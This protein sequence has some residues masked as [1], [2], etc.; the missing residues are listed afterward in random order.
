MA[1]DEVL[2]GIDPTLV[3]LALDAPPTTAVAMAEALAA[4]LQR[5]GHDPAALTVDFGLGAAEAGMALALRR[6]GFAGPALRADGRRVHEGGATE[7]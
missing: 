7:A 2:A 1:L 5:H 3:A 6:S 4:A